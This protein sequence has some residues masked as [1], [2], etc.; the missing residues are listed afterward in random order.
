MNGTKLPTTYEGFSFHSYDTE[1]LPT[2]HLKPAEIL[3]FRDNAFDIYHKNPNFLK[4]VK[5]KFGQ[6]A[7]DNINE[8]LKVKLKRKI[9]ETK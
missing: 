3:E 2:L 4:R 7:V 5:S 6:I 9:L 1:P 8:M